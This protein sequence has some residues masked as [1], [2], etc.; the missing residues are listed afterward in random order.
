MTSIFGAVFSMGYNQFGQLG[1]GHLNSGEGNMHP[2]QICK[3]TNSASP[4]IVDVQATICGASFAFSDNGQAYRWGYNQVEESEFPIYDRFNS[5]IN[6]R[7]CP[8]FYKSPN[9]SL[10]TYSFFYSASIIFHPQL[11]QSR[12]EIT[13]LL[14]WM[15]QA[16]F[17][18]GDSVS[19]LEWP[20]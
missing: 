16:T 19:S 20:S 18:A 11:R 3:F 8:L 6:Y 4:F 2:S 12:Q 5:I 9:P 7:A 1:L 13:S 14:P 15:N 17:M 10:I